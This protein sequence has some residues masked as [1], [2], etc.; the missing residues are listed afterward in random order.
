[1]VVY[2]QAPN[3]LM[4]E[5][6]VRATFKFIYCGTTVAENF[7]VDLTGKHFWPEAPRV[8]KVPWPILFNSVL[9]GSCIRF[10]TQ[11]IDW[12][13][14]KFSLIHFGVFRLAGDDGPERYALAT[15]VFVGR[16]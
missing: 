10:G 7:P 2:R 8:S 3:L 1:M 11:A 5:R 16:R 6:I 15:F 13:G 14:P 9:D 12:P 4:A